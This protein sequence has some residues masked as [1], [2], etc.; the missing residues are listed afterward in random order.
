MISANEVRMM[1]RNIKQDLVYCEEQIKNAARG[2]NC[3]G[4]VFYPKNFVDIDS[5]INI[6][7]NFGYKVK[8]IQGFLSINWGANE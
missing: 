1:Q 7:T 6:L 2:P 3:V 4:V 5:T 8:L